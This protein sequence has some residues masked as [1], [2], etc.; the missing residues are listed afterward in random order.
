MIRRLLIIM[1]AMLLLVCSIMPAAYAHDSQKEHDDDLL[2]VLFGEGYSLARDK[3][4]IFQAIAD[5]AALCI[6]QFSVNAESRS[7]EKQFNDL[8]QRVGFSISFNDISA[9]P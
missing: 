4:P 8:K 6:D 5:A 1:T 9:I 3:K 2:Y 7:K